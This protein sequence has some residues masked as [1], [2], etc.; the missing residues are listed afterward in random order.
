MTAKEAQR[1]TSLAKANY[2]RTGRAEIKRAIHGGD[3]DV[4]ELLTDPPEVCLRMAVGEL[5]LALPRYGNERVRKLTRQVGTEPS[6]PIGRLTE[7]QR[8]G[9]AE[10]IR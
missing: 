4:R 8:V 7:R 9:I 5:L 1:M 6:R 10:L 3:R 2:V